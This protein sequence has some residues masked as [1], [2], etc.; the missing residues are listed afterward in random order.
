MR[1]D[2][3]IG[4]LP[5]QADVAP[6]AGGKPAARQLN[7]LLATGD[8]DGGRRATL[9]F[10]AAC[11]ARAMGYEVTVYLVGDGTCWGL[12]GHADYFHASGYPPLNQLLDNFLCAGGQ[13]CKCSNPTES[14]RELPSLES[15]YRL[16]SEV[17]IMGFVSFI[18]QIGGSNAITF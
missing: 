8:D 5:Q 17:Q 2:T 13:L 11:S 14:F 4:C 12:E 9:A 7:I 3:G 16:R 6:L 1:A 15:Q 10:S 18:D